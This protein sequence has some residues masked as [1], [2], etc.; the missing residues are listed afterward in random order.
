[1]KPPRSA[2]ITA[3]LGETCG[4][5][6]TVRVR[7]PGGRSLHSRVGPEDLELGAEGT[8][9][10]E[11]CAAL[12]VVLV[13]VE[14]DQENVFAKDGTGGAALDLVEIDGGFREE[15]EDLREQARPVVGEGEG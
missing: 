6:R 12:G 5:V 8:D 11:D 13:V 15:G 3:R 9:G 4:N 7:Q 10:G 2:R 1:M 14:I